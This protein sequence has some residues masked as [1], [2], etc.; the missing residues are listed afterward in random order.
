MDKFKENNRYDWSNA[1]LKDF[2]ISFSRKF[3]RTCK[4]KFR[5]NARAR[6]KEELIKEK[7]NKI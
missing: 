4:N 6:L 7:L 3:K 2:N 5:K 1:E